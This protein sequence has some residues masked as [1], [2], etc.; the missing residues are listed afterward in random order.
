MADAFPWEEVAGHCAHPR[1]QRAGQLLRAN[2][3]LEVRLGNGKLIEVCR[4]CWE[5]IPTPPVV[6]QH[7][8]VMPPMSVE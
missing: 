4:L 8:A 3:R 5:V 7:P 2:C 1:E 6:P